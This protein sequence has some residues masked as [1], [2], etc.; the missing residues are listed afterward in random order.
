[1]QTN[2]LILHI[3]RSCFRLPI[4]NFDLSAILFH[5]LHGSGLGHKLDNVL[6][7]LGRLNGTVG[8]LIVACL[9]PR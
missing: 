5:M 9:R 1:M 3:F 2:T 6:Q 8:L 7:Y 4:Q